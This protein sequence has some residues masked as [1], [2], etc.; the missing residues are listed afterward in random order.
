MA[1]NLAD[2]KKGESGII[3]SVNSVPKMKRHLADMGVT[4]GSI[5]TLKRRAP[6]GDPLL[7]IVMDYRLSIRKSEAQ[8]IIIEKIGERNG[9]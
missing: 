2:L 5:V 4:P 7:F 1:V 8:N 6:L 3:V 9:R